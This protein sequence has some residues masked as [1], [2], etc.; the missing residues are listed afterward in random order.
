MRHG[1][2]P[3]AR[4]RAVHGPAPE[5]PGRAG[6][7]V[8]E[9]LA[10]PLEDEGPS[11]QTAIGRP[12]TSAFATRWSSSAENGAAQAASPMDTAATR[13]I[14]GSRGSRSAPKNPRSGASRR[15]YPTYGLRPYGLSYPVSRD[16]TR[17]SGYSSFARPHAK[18]FAG[19]KSSVVPT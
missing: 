18:V 11:L 8:A 13:S 4:E 5:V 6:L 9:R 19:T 3:G 15:S 1:L 17:I 7:A 2:E 12:P 14:A 16:S 10:R